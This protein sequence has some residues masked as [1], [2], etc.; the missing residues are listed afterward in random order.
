MT[1]VAT[2]EVA[3]LAKGYKP[4]GCELSLAKLRD[5]CEFLAPVHLHTKIRDELKVLADVQ[6]TTFEV[7]E[8]GFEVFVDQHRDRLMSLVKS[9]CYLEKSINVCRTYIPVPRA[10]GI[11]CEQ[12]MKQSPLGASASASAT[13]DTKSVTIGHS[14]VSVVFGDLATQPVSLY[15]SHPIEAAKCFPPRMSA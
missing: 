7:N 2:A 9:K 12:P 4:Y 10:R 6:E 11:E 3:R 8:P 5:E 1:H 14:T 13:S 15:S